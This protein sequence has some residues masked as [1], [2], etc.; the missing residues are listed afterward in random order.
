MRGDDVRFDAVDVQDHV[1]EALVRVPD[2]AARALVEVLLLG[3]DR[4]LVEHRAPAVL[5][6]REEQAPP[7]ASRPVLPRPTTGIRY[8]YSSAGI[9]ARAEVRLEGVAAGQV[10]ESL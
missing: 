2:P 8:G 5:G 6:V 7:V 4:P 3:H 10:P 1:P 9:L